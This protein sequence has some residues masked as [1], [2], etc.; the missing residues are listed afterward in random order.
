MHAAGRLRSSAP[1]RWPSVHCRTAAPARTNRHS[2]CSRRPAR[3]SPRFPPSRLMQHLP[4]R[5]EGAR[6]PAREGRCHT[7]L[8]WCS[9]PA[10]SLQR[11]LPLFNLPFTRKCRLAPYASIEFSAR[12]PTGHRRAQLAAIRRRSNRTGGQSGSESLVVLVWRTH[13]AC[14]ARS[15]DSCRGVGVDTAMQRLMRSAYAKRL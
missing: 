15:A 6:S 14:P 7:S 12:Q 3:R 5:S 11:P 2:R 4:G 10:F 13:L 9:S 1:R 8:N